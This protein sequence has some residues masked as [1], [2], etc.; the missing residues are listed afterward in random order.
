[1]RITES[2]L[3]KTIRREIVREK[4]R[5]IFRQYLSASSGRMNES[6][7]ASEIVGKIQKAIYILAAKKAGGKLW[8]AVV[9]EFGEKAVDYVLNGI[10]TIPV[11]GNFASG[12]KLGADIF[13]TG[14]KAYSKTKEAKE[15]AYDLLKVAKGEYGTNIDDGTAERDPIAKI[16]NIDDR[17]E[18]P[19][20]N[21]FLK[22]FTN[23][24]V[25]YLVS[26]PNAE[27]ESEQSAAEESLEKYMTA[28]AQ[29]EEAE[30]PSN[31]V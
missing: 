9:E 16:L 8:D 4:H 31:P 25:K 17:M 13:K 5:K 24:Y 28:Q 12:I 10:G 26:D 19:L 11:I 20:K 14:F 18:D 22:K 27:F 6:I 1:M 3:R 21:D 7:K 2:Q 29:W 23:W 15:D 30:G